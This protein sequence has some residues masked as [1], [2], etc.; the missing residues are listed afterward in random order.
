MAAAKFVPGVQGKV[1]EETNKM[2]DKATKHF[3]I[4]GDEHVF[5]AI[6]E[7]GLSE[8]T[9]VKYLEQCAA[10]EH[11]GW[12]DGKVSGKVYNGEPSVISVMNA[13]YKL[14]CV[15]N[16]LHP[17]VFPSIRKFEAETIRMT[18]TMLHGG[19]ETCGT[20][21][22]GG[23]ESILMAMKT[24]REYGR[25]AKGIQFPEVIMSDGAHAAFD[26]A[27]EYFGIKIVRTPINCD[28]TTNIEAVAAR[29]NSNTVGI[30]G[31]A[32]NYAHGSIDDIEALAELAISR[33][34][35]LH[36]D[37]CLGGF[38]LPWAQKLGYG[39]KPFDF[40]VKGVSTISCDTHKYGFGP[41]GESTL[42]FANRSLRRYMYFIQP[43]WNGGIYASP[44]VAGSRAGAPIA[45]TWAVLVTTGEKGYMAATK[46]MMEAHR[47]I[48]EGTKHIKE[49]Q[50]ICDH[51]SPVLAWKSNEID[52]FMIIDA[53]K[54]K[55]WVLD[56]LQSPNAIHICLTVRHIGKGKEFVRDLIEAV[57][58]IKSDP[59]Q[60]TGGMAPVYGMAAS[61]PDR[62]I[63][64]DFVAGYLDRLLDVTGSGE[65]V[66]EPN[67][68]S[69]SNSQ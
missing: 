18:C 56:A 43:D 29:I 62:T 22:A 16:A 17:E 25:K 21:T 31:S 66:A 41:K 44:T 11:P 36:V 15:S 39:V 51:P 42:L 40:Q 7:E 65:V 59:A 69:S 8:E 9:L 10:K 19:E 2:L 53:M 30:V 27:Q 47:E 35:L 57:E 67:A 6:P 34:L 28:G 64:R 1:D 5:G 26:K 3:K 61:I 14:Y 60:F 45:G 50:L 68:A 23:T 58:L 13:V 46:G 54:R 52:I 20:L 4:A 37:A 33:N 38:F 12:K 48:V 63:I 55:R 49:L 24:Y 32:P